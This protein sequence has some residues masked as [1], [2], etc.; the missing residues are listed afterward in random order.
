MGIYPRMYN[1]SIIAAF[2]NRID[3]LKLVLAGFDRQTEKDFELIIA[4]DGSRKDIVEEIKVIQT[5]HSFPLKHIWQDDKG[6]RKNKIL[7]KAVVNSESDYLIFIDA[8]CVPHRGFVEGHLNFAK[9]QA[10]L[11]GR[12]VNLS[13]KITSELSVQNVCE[14]F[15]EKKF[16]RLS[17]DGIF[18]E[19][20]DVE[21]GIY[22][23]NKFLLSLF[24]KKNRGLLGCNFSLFKNDLIKINGFDERYEAP[25]IGE[26]SDVQFRLELSGVKIK[27]INHIAVQYHLF[28]KLQERPQRNLALFEEIQKN[29]LAFTP[30]GLTK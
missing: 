8:D 30:F 3:Y 26:D 14:G 7:N 25:S 29:K 4:D 15:L 17:L 1:A 23:R 6:F 11:T 18:G 28:H 10:S 9:K 2:Y 22:I 27:S 12:R 19:S 5:V 24:N 20:V 21:K 13:Q 16:I